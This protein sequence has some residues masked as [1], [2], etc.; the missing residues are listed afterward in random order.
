MSTQPAFGL[1][2]RR[3]AGFKKPAI[4]DAMLILGLCMAAILVVLTLVFGLN[5]PQSANTG[6]LMT[7][8]K[9]PALDGYLLGTDQLGRSL[10]GRVAAGMPWAL[11]VAMVATSISL[12]VGTAIGLVAA[13]L[14]GWP[15]RIIRMVIDTVIAFPSL[16][17]AVTVIALLGRGFWPLA[18]TLGLATWPI[19][20]RVVFAEAMSIVQRDYVLAADLAGVAWP[21]IMV[22][23]VLPALRPTLLT[24]FAFTFADMLIAESAL[25]FLGLGVPLS[26]PS[27]GNILS[28]SRESL[29]VAPWMMLAPAAAII[30]SV[31][32]LNLIGDGISAISRRNSGRA[33]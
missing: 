9:P 15:R 4:A 7:R 21:K 13:S 10:A 11:G 6:S 19:S 23:H 31:V 32:A 5:P 2:K 8:F 18:L 24:M 20:A 12:I 28:E 17:I 14:D 1:F 3:H 16:V 26:A 27:W 25:S 22:F 30:F 29:V 33:S